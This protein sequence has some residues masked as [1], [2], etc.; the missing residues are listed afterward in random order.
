MRQAT[1]KQHGQKLQLQCT[2]QCHYEHNTNANWPVSDLILR[3]RSFLKSDKIKKGI[4]DHQQ[5]DLFIKTFD[6]LST[7][8][9]KFMNRENTYSP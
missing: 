9:I 4:D 6:T 8:E 5:V 3:Q 7:I 1:V 2:D